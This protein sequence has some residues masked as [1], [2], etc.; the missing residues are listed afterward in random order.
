MPFRGRNRRAK[1]DVNTYP[2]SVHALPYVFG[3]FERGVGRAYVDDTKVINSVRWCVGLIG[4]SQT[5]VVLIEDEVLSFV[6]GLRVREVYC[7]RV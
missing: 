7:V 5:A 1:G 6:S 4:G 3:P 2:I